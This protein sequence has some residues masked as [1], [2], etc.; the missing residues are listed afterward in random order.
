MPLE[1]TGSLSGGKFKGD[2]LSGNV[3][4][5]PLLTVLKISPSPCRIQTHN[6]F[7]MGR[8]IYNL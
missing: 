7:I 4:A 3:Y 5:A 1:T 2:E 6:L 8:G